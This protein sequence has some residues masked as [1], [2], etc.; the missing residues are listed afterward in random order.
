MQ[1]FQKYCAHNVSDDDDIFNRL[2]FISTFEGGNKEIIHHGMNILALIMLEG[3][4]K[5]AQKVLTEKD[6]RILIIIVIIIGIN[7]MTISVSVLG[8]ASGSAEEPQIFSGQ[9]IA[10]PV[11]GILSPLISL[12]IIICVSV[13]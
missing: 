12:G 4:K 9:R 10:A 6:V 13:R 8:F 2:A 3:Y 1:G 5:S 11:S 7:Q